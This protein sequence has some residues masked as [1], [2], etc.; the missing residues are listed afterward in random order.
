MVGNIRSMVESAS[1]TIDLNVVGA[2]TH[3]TLPDFIG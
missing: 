3:H 2:L 1:H